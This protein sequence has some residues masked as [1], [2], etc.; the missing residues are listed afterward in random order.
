MS[1]LIKKQQDW[2][3]DLESY[4]RFHKTKVNRYTHGIGIPLILFA[5]FCFLGR[6]RFELLTISL[7]VGSLFYLGI[8]VF[9]YQ[10]HKKLAFVLALWCF[11]VFLLGETVSRSAYSLFLPMTLG[12]FL[13]GWG[14]Q[15]L[16]HYLE[17]N[18]PAFL[19][20]AAHLWR[21]PLFITQ[22]LVKKL[23]FKV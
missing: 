11:P 15:F 8:C 7:S 19:T 23:G 4:Q 20:G 17:H 2:S 10:I 9:Y 3:Q 12:S 14:F 16:G 5:I 13:L 6:F 21:G 1:S 22:E 18:R